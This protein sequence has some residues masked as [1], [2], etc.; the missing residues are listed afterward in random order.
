[1]ENK[2]EDLFTCE[3]K[4]PLL[5]KKEIYFFSLLEDL[6]L[7]NFKFNK[8]GLLEGNIGGR[9]FVSIKDLSEEQ[10]NLIENLIEKSKD[11]NEI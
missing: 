10:L 7:N 6:N 2:I 9:F 3:L 8:D 1:M 5:N 11:K 4:I